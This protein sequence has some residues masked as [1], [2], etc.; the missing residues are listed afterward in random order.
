MKTIS[1]QRSSGSVALHLLYTVT[2]AVA[3][4]SAGCSS[5]VNDAI[6]GNQTSTIEKALREGKA[7]LIAEKT[8]FE[9]SVGSLELI[10][11]AGGLRPPLTYWRRA[12]DSGQLVLGG[13]STQEGRGKLLTKSYHFFIVEP[14]RYDLLG[15]V[16]K[17]RMLSNLY[18]LPRATEPIRSTLG[19]VKLSGTT[20]PSL[21]EYQAWIPPQSHMRLMP[22]NVVATWYTPGRWQSEVGS[23]QISA[24]FVDMRGMAAHDQDGEANLAS[25]MLQP[26]QL[27]L[28]GDFGMEFTHGKCDLPEQNQWVCPIVTLTLRPAISDFKANLQKDMEE[29][30]YPPSLVHAVQTARIVPGRFF[31]SS[32]VEPDSLSGHVRVRAV[33]GR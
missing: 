25:F 30:G 28:I 29:I 8:I 12:G 20:L 23:R 13:S 27:A 26:G 3:L 18:E 33:S 17:T 31:R 10:S 11:V 24:G 4:M 32:K 21:Y 1:R 16:H 22:Q 15:Y 9:P 6:V 2:L 7:V 5:L 19:F 14:G